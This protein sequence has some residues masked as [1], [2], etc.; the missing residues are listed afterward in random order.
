[1]S[2]FKV[3]TTTSVILI[4]WLLIDLT[5]GYSSDQ[6]DCKSS[7]IPKSNNKYDIIFECSTSKSGSG[8]TKLAVEKYY[9]NNYGYKRRFTYDLSTNTMWC[10]FKGQITS[11]R[12]AYFKR[13]YPDETYIEPLQNVYW[14][15]N[16]KLQMS[17]IATEGIYYMY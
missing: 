4:G 2:G 5:H 10:N 3:V 7:Y 15:N 16:V 14:A 12:L 6:L 8:F 9:K 13:N 17:N 1:M 11:E